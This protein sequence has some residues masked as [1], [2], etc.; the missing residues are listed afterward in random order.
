M[1]KNLFIL[2]LGGS[3]I[4]PD[5]IDVKFLKKF[6]SLILRQTQKGKHFIIITGGGKICRVYQDAMRRLA[7]FTNDDLDWIGIYTTYTNAL[8]VKT[9]L[10]NITHWQI[11]ANPFEKKKITKQVLVA[12]GYRPG[13]STD[14][15]VVRI[16]QTYGAKTIIN[17]SNI[18]YVYTKDPKKFKDAKPIRRI[19]WKNFQKLMGDVWQPGA[20]LPFDPIASRI[21][22]RLK[23]SVI[24]LN[25]RNL[26]NLENCL[27]QKEFKGTVIE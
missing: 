16:A 22:K 6:R 15:D 17:L 18:D 4:F 23:L 20:N 7:N 27:E 12:G 5:G 3:L 2:S 10:A 8:L 9:A 13:W 25:G 21:A 26:K 11:L 14:Y 24:I 19:S 1:S